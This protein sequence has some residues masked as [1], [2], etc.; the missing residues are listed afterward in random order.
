[1][2]D[3]YLF[4]SDILVAPMM[5]AGTERNV[6]LPKGNWIDYQSGKT[7]PTRM[8]CNEEAAKSCYHSGARRCCYPRPTQSTDKINW[9]DIELKIYGNKEKATDSFCLPSDNKLTDIIL[10]KSGS[11]YQLEKGQIQGV[12]YRINRAKM[13]FYKLFFIIIYFSWSGLSVK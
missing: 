1:M 6:Y 9:S 2:K 5:E 3:Q 4:G 8:E 13:K 10:T 11:N 12:H 7:Y